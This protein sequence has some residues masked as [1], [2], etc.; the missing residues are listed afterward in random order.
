[1][2]KMEYQDKKKR[3][4]WSRRAFIGTTGLLGTGLVVGVGGMAY[5]SKQIKKYS[6]A[7]L[8]TGDSLNAWI[9]IAPDNTVTLAIARAEM[10][11]GVY[12]SLPQMIAEELE[13]EMNKIKVVHPQPEAPYSNTFLMTQESSN[14]YKGLSA[15]E[16]IYSF[17]P[18]VGTGGSTSVA[19]GWYNM[20]YAGATARE[21]L[22]QAAAERWDVPI[23]DCYA[24]NGQVINRTNRNR[25]NYGDI[26]EAAAKIKLDG[27]PELKK[28]SDYKIIGQPVQRLDI[29]DK[30]DGTAEF[31][32]DIRLEGM[33]YAAI[34]HPATIGGKITKIT[35]EDEVL[36]MNGVK[37]VILT[38][39][40]AAAVVADNTWAAD[41]G[42]KVMEVEEETTH[43]ALST[44]TITVEMKKLLD[45]APIA[46]PE[47]HG[48][49]ES[50]FGSDIE[51]VTI[52]AN[53]EVPYIAHATMEPMNCTVLVKD[54]TC[55]SWVGHQ[56]P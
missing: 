33:L 45:E 11:Q 40:G 10:G 41:N 2:K 22:I 3:N 15:M 19:D 1:L 17:L 28:K 46:T 37:K 34:K 44:A 23:S 29:P 26:A 38:E 52:E 7:G 54:G 47:N 21:M 39:F 35:N 42:T 55:E 49:V 18:L 32:L 43:A 16:K 53:Y 20:R 14:I 24:E 48:D 31:G 50:A 8:G 30:V 27:L 13:I 51:G 56:A 5:V 4:K 36:S 12:T 9:R 25:I 6:G